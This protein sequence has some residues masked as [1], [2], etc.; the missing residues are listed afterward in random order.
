M[1]FTVTETEPDLAPVALEVFFV[2]VIVLYTEFPPTVPEVNA[3]ADIPGIVTVAL[4]V[5]RLYPTNW[6]VSPS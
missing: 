3:V 5:P 6:I 2:R 4:L 1:L